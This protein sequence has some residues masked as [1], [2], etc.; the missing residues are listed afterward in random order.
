MNSIFKKILPLF[1]YILHPLFISVYAVLIFFLFGDHYFLYPDIYLVIIQIV[2]ITIF[3]PI[4]FY[5]LLLSM[6]KVDS[7]M[8]AKRNQ[9]IIPLVIHAIL[10]YILIKKSITVDLFTELHFFFLGSLISTFLAL[11]MIYFKQKVSLHMIGIMAL[12]IFT[13]GISLHFQV[14]L[15]VLIVSLILC[16]GLVASSR[17]EMKAHTYTELF[18]GSLIGIVPQVGLFYFWL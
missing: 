5:Y 13:I 6:G 15:I 9:R 3:I 14:R 8:L 7:I 17:L 2:I 12:T 16:N 1:S 4:T 10:L 11:I 18:L